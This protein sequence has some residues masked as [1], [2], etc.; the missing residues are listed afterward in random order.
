LLDGLPA[1]D[2][3][4]PP[5]GAGGD[6]V[7]TVTTT[8]YRLERPVP[9]QAASTGNGDGPKSPAGDEDADSVTLPKAKATG[10]RP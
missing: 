6:S 10:H 4:A 2:G 9:S 8:S 1:K 3:S 7:S 5:I